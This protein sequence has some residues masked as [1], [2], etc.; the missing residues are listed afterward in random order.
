VLTTL[1]IKK[2][3]RKDIEL[4]KDEKGFIRAGLPRFNR[5]FG[6]DALITAWQLLDINPD[7]TRETIKILADLEGDVFNETTEEEPGK[8]LHEAKGYFPYNYYGSI[9]A[10]PLFLIL[11]SF[12]FCK[13]KDTRFIK[14]YWEKIRRAVKWTMNFGDRDNDGFIEYLPKNFGG[15][16]HQGWK[17]GFK[18]HLKIEPPVAIVEVQGYAYL[19]Y[20]EIAELAKLA[21]D[22]QLSQTLLSKAI[23]LKE[24]FNQVFWMPEKRYFCLGLDRGKNPR[25][26]ITSNPGHLLFTDI[27]DKE[28]AADVV[29]KLFSREL[30]TPFGIRTHSINEPDFNPT[31]S[32]LGSIWPHDNWIISQGLKKLGYKEEYEKIKTALLATYQK[33]GF[34]PEFYGV[35]DNKITLAMEKIVSH[36]Q[37]WASAGLLNLL[38][39]H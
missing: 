32:H 4:L 14:N 28:R 7:I 35:V 27:I 11:C 19:A 37:A 21:K 36:P 34:V 31:S 15:L 23:N 20:L 13:T 38:S 18:D 10:T 1:E 29:K 12:Y 2:Q 39:T 33:I 30:W 3:L 24:K 5:L 17:D 8:I 26:A 6:R 16:Y 22:E 9:D 25:R